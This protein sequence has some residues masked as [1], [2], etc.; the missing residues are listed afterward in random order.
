M[1]GQRKRPSLRSRFSAPVCSSL[2]SQR[3]R[4]FRSSPKRL[5]YTPGAP[6]VPRASTSQ[7]SV[8]QVPARNESTARERLQ[9]RQER[10]AQEEE[11]ANRPP[12][13]PFRSDTTGFSTANLPKPP[14][15]R[16]G[17]PTP[18]PSATRAPPLDYLRDYH[19]DRIPIR[20]YMPRLPRQHIVKAFKMLLRSKV[21]STK[22]PWI[23]WEER[24][25]PYR[26]LELVG[27]HHLFP[28]VKLSL[29]PTQP[30]HHQHLPA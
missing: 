25:W 8:P 7:R 16:P 12:P 14:A 24:V 27:P 11:E 18:P 3:S 4:L 19:R 6:A 26:A 21:F 20:I 30:S 10:E 15:F 22:V 29:L 1:D 23:D 13:G 17:Q 5:D 9:Q 28:L 2:Y